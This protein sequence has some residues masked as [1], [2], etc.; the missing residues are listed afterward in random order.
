M[1]FTLASSPSLSVPPRTRILSKND[2]VNSLVVAVQYLG[3]IKTQ[4]I[5]TALAP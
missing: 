5:V 1:I 3:E 2:C 4:V